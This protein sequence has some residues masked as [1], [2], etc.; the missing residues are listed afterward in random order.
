M[1]QPDSSQSRNSSGGALSRK[2]RQAAE[3]VDRI[4]ENAARLFANQGFH[5]TSTREIALAADVSEGTLYNYFDNKNDLLFNILERLGEYEL[6]TDWEQEKLP[7]DARDFLVQML[8]LRR[9]FVEKNSIM[10]QAILSE[11]LANAE[12]RERYNQ[13]MIAPTVEAIE[14]NLQQRGAQETA[15]TDLDIPAFTRVIVAMYLGLFI[16]EIL[17]DPLVKNEWDRLVSS[18]TNLVFEGI[19][20]SGPDQP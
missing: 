17:G 8:W 5:R 20:P 12:L 4:L 2:E 19:G 13:Q 14:T 3:R 10:L 6:P 9:D 11:I 18:F 16:L 1:H 15:R 7:L